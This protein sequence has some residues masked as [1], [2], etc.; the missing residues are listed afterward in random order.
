MLP[1]PDEETQNL[2]K[3]AFESCKDKIYT[4]LSS[5]PL[6]VSLKNLSC[7]SIKDNVETTRVLY[8]KIDDGNGLETL[9]DISNILISSMLS[10][11]VIKEKQ[12]SH[13]NVKDGKYHPNKFHI[14]ILNSTFSRKERSWTF[15]AKPILEKFEKTNLG[16]CIVEDIHIS[17]RFHFDDKGF[18]KPLITLPLPT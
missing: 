16:E 13:I 14:T 9:I 15:N 4:I 12:L 11:G 10:N 2:A 6:K 17:T 8:I 5:K 7:I 18:Y 3:K 1:L